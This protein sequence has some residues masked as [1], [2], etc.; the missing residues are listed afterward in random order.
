LAVGRAMSLVERHILQSQLGR[1]SSAQRHSIGRRPRIVCACRGPALGRLKLGKR[2]R[3][4]T[5][6]LR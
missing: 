2:H 4:G 3:T 6:V 1:P 5:R